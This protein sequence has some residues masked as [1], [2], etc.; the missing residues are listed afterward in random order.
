MNAVPATAAALA[1]TLGAVERLLGPAL[2][3]NLVPETL[4]QLSRID[5]VTPAA[6]AAVYVAASRREAA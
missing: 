3:V 6:V 1:G 2:P 4:D 5:G